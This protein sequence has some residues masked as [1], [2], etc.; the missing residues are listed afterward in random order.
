MFTVIGKSI[1]YIDGIISIWS[2][3]KVDEARNDIFRLWLD[4]KQTDFMFM[5]DTDMSFP[6]DTLDRLLEHDKDIVGGL[7]FTTD[8]FL[9]KVTPT[10][11]VLCPTE[12]GKNSLEPLWD[13]PLDSLVPC[14][15]TGA[16]CMLVKRSAAE[17]IR[18]AKGRDHPM[19]W[20]AHGMHGSTRIG[21]DI[22]FCLTARALGIEVWVD[23]S[24][25]IGHVKPQFVG[26]AEYVISL[27]RS[28]HPAY[29]ERE[30]V[31]IYQRMVNGH[32]SIDGDKPVPVAIPV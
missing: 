10:I 30:Q 29:T 13:Y 31:P 25:A 19:P 3:P 27:S 8:P 9:S 21:E 12:D 22:A 11:A 26:Q 14:D 24:L 5:V 23:T 4:T 20:F 16:A 32:S 1:Q 17:R 7:C 2:G 6:N 28:I 18:E 15:A